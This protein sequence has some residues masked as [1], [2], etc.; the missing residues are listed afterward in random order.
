MSRSRQLLSF[1]LLNACL[2]LIAGAE[3][4]KITRGPYLQAASPGSVHLVWRIRQDTEPVVRYGLTPGVLDRQSAKDALKIRRPAASGESAGAGE[5]LSAAPAETRQYEAK[6]TGLQPDTLYYYG[7]FD[8]ETRLTAADDTY[9]F[10]TLPQP[11]TERPL[12][13]WVVGDSGTG[14]KVQAKV[15]TVMRNWLIKEKRTLDLYLHVGDMA[16]GSGMDSEFQGYFFQPYDATLRNTVCWPAFG[17]HEGRSSKGSTGIGPY[18][19][20]YITPMA[21][22][23]GGVPSG[24]ESY[25]SFDIGRV[26][27]ISLN[28]FDVSRQS[29][30][31]M[32]Q[33]LKADLEKTKADWIISFFHHPPYTKGTHDS[34][35]A[36]SD[37]EL[38]EMREN[39]M[40]ILVVRGNDTVRFCRPRLP[41]NLASLY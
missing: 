35:N 21:G 7:M 40:P 1:A 6:I 5:P 17:N 29:D 39:I 15:H 34:D 16:Y 26:H 13:M 27:F 19:D 28:S 11:G 24:T 8:G 41:A 31:A 36:K 25:Y 23:S 4:A 33:W 9:S 37:R 2:P 3:A 32:A 38:I 30:G 10:R 18:F 22:E 12:L 14:N 20:A